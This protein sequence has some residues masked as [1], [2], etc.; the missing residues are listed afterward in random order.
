MNTKLT[1]THLSIML[2]AG[3]IW[4]LGEVALGAGLKSCAH[5]VSGSLMTGVAL[6]C[7]A[8]ALFPLVKFATGVPACVHPGT[9]IPLAIYFGPVAMAVSAI[10]VPLGL[11]TGDW[12]SRRYED[13]VANIQNR[14]ATTLLSPATAVASLALVLVIR[15]LV[16]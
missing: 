13:L 2:I 8:V 5:L 3:S 14:L 7:I 6:F 1:G 10:T 16:L 11:Y 15:T 4:G 9:T 12:F